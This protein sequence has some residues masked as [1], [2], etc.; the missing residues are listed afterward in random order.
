MVLK[1][2]KDR[3]NRERDARGKFNSRGNTIDTNLTRAYTSRELELIKQF[4]ANKVA[5]LQANLKD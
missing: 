4:E 2:N 3:A 1:T 5:T